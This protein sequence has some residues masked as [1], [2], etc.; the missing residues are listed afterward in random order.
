MA[1]RKSSS[2]TGKRS[3]AASVTSTTGSVANEERQ[4][5]KTPADAIAARTRRAAAKQTQATGSSS[6]SGRHE[7]GA[8]EPDPQRSMPLFSLSHRFLAIVPPSHSTYSINGT[9]YLNNTARKPAGI[10]NHVAPAQT[11]ST[12]STRP[13]T[14]S[15]S[16]RPTHSSALSHHRNWNFQRAYQQT[17]LMTSRR[18]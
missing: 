12:K 9:A 6:N 8:E 5:S 1:P 11:A 3:R 7:T 16:T 14:P 13:S 15:T 10:S 18:P 17:G 4:R 2:K